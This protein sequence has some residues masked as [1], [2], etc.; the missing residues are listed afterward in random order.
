MEKIIFLRALLISATLFL[1]TAEAQKSDN[2]ITL[3]LRDGK[4]FINGDSVLLAGEPLTI[5][6][7]LTQGALLGVQTKDNES[8]AEVVEVLPG[9][10]AEKAGLQKGDII[11][12]VNTT[13][14]ANAAALSRVIGGM[15][16]QEVVQITL[17]RNKE[18]KELSATL[19]TAQ[20]LYQLNDTLPVF[21]GNPYTYRMPNPFF[22]D[23]SSPRVFLHRQPLPGDFT[24]PARRP[25]LGM[26]IQETEN[27]EGVTVLKVTPQSPAE[28][29]GLK[30]GDLIT[31]ING[32]KITGIGDA[33]RQ[34]GNTKETEYQLQVQ[35]NKKTVILT[36]KVPKKLRTADL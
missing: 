10:P 27:D 26:Q 8:G 5:L 28:K 24:S 33:K 4:M 32:Q 30:K 35:R 21:R 12:Q 7:N 23:S 2:R 15:R 17:L 1:S 3:E 18:E 19:G 36:L 31:A 25:G 22:R 11:T 9:S 6:R 20:S 14:V 13:P 16:P 29:A 34:T